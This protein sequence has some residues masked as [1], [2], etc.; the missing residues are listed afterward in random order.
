MKANGARRRDI[1]RAAR[2]HKSTD[3]FQETTISIGENAD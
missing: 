1:Y 3:I 2:P